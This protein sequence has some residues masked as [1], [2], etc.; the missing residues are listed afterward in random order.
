MSNSLQIDSSSESSDAEDMF[1]FLETT[2][3]STSSSD[4]SDDQYD[5]HSKVS[6]FMQTIEDF[7]LSDFRGHFRMRRST[8]E[9]LTGIDFIN[10]FNL[11]IKWVNIF[12]EMY[13]ENKLHNAHTGGLKEIGSKK[14]VCMY[15]WYIA[16]TITYRQ[17]SNL[18]DVCIST[19][20]KTVNN[21][22]KWLVSISNIYIKWPLPHDMPDV[23]SEFE[24]KQKIPHIIGAIDVTHIRI[25]KL[26]EHGADYFNKKKYYSISMQGVVDGNKKFTDIYCG[27]AGSMHDA[28]VLRRSELYRNVTENRNQL[29]PADEILI[30]DSGYPSLDWLVTPFKNNGYL[31]AREKKFNFIHS[32]TRVVVENAFGALKTRFR[33]LL[34]FTEQIHVDLIVNI[35]VSACV[36]HNICIIQQDEYTTEELLPQENDPLPENEDEMTGIF[37]RQLLI[38]E[39]VTKNVLQ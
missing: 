14:E 19:A 28:R 30:G 37:R 21:V 11:T 18:F 23:I 22:S 13:E 33:R 10:L 2:S 8:V 1:K 34:Y 3:D 12:L 16:N 26:K 20:W 38:D 31:S 17:L 4:H 35:V 25:R 27:E 39:L 29:F 15:L 6:N 9:I 24:R 5:S 32:S 7:S 36:L